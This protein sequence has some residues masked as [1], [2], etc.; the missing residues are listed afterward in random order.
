MMV[1]YSAT[2]PGVR[3]CVS[4]SN[5]QFP[6]PNSACCLRLQG[7]RGSWTLGVDVTNVVEVLA[8]LNVNEFFPSL[9]GTG[10]PVSAMLPVTPLGNVTSV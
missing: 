7:S 4:T 5:S 6:T 2:G 8:Y 1:S 10:V 3:L 9:S